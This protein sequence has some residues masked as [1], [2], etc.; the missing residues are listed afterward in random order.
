[1]TRTGPPGWG[2]ARRTPRTPTPASTSA[3]TIFSGAMPPVPP[4]TSRRTAID[5]AVNPSPRSIAA[6]ASGWSVPSGP[7]RRA[8]AGPHLASGALGDEPPGAHD[9]DVGAHLLHLGQQV[10]GDEDR[11]AVGG[12]ATL[13]RLRTSRVPC[14][15]RPF[16]GSSRT[17]RSR[18]PEQGGGDGQPL[19]HAERVGAVALAGG[20]EQA[21]PVQRGVD[22]RA[23]RCA[24][25]AVRSAASSRR[26]LARPDR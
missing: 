25:S 16:V 23:A 15:S 8:A 9:A 24:G 12:R 13:M 4:R 5:A 14:G 11:R 10:A 6:A 3:A 21:D 19:P 22:P 1:M 20:G 2:C 17:S 18:G 26:R 7:G